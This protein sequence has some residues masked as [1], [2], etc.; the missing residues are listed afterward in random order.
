MIAYVGCY[1]ADA[2]PET[3]GIFTVEVG[4]DGDRLAVIGRTAEPRQAGYLS[5]AAST[6]TLYAVDER[7]NDGRGATCRASVHSFSVSRRDGGITR[8]NSRPAPGPFPTYL[9]LDERRRTLLCASHGGFDH[10][11]HI[12]RTPDGGWSVEYLYDDSALLLYRLEGDGRVGE[13]A[14]VLV[15]TGHGTDPNSSPQAGGH[16]QSGPHAHCAVIDPSGDW[17][18]VCDKGTDQIHVYA[19]GDTLGKSSSH[20]FPAETGPRHL[21]FDPVTGNAFV[22]CEFSSELAS[23]AFDPASGTLRALD[24][25]SSVDTDHRGPNEPADVRV[26]PGGGLVYVNNRGEDSLAWFRIGDGGTLTRLGHVPLARS[27]HPGL[28]ARSF[29]FDPTGSFVLV[30]DRPADLVRSYRVDGVTGALTPLAELT[31][32]QPAFIA[33]VDLPTVIGETP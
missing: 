17:A 23:L 9:A 19:L 33:V 25:V 6:G 31:I 14:D 4:A 1:T 12:V 30:A 22:T 16:A 18:L 3:G 27:A 11:E 10:V 29:A 15:M 5:Y 7:K 32:P 21:A 24:T 26:H 20:R 2:D 13:L 8:L 28:A